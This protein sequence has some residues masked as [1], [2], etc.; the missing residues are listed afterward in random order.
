MENSILK[1]S[2]DNVKNWFVSENQ[3]GSDIYDLLDKPNGNTLAMMSL[4]DFDSFG[5]ERKIASRIFKAVEGVLDDQEEDGI[6]SIKKYQRIKGQRGNNECLKCMPL[7]FV[8][9]FPRYS[10]W[11]KHP[12]YCRHYGC[13]SRKK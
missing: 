5:I 9:Y 6:I 12:G 3:N 4:A 10:S 8:L 2:F 11:L 7:L 1:W 13:T